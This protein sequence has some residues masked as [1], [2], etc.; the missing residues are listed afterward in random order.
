MI[1]GPCNRIYAQVTPEPAMASGQATAIESGKPGTEDP[2]VEKKPM[3]SVSGNDVKPSGIQAEAGEWFEKGVLFSVYGNYD[4]AVKAFKKAAE[5]VP[6]WSEAHFQLG[7][8][9]GEAGR[10][11]DAVLSIDRAIELDDSK[12]NYYYGRGRVYLMA[13]DRDK[14]MEDFSKAADMSDEDAKRYMEKQRS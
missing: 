14:A 9:Y 3:A 1:A 12:A 13:G 2:M 8:S 7:V 10:Y 4:A 11:E 5:L 6:G